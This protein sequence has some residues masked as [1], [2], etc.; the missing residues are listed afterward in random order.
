MSALHDLAAGTWALFLGTWAVRI[1]FI[2]ADC[3]PVVVKFSGGSSQYDRIVK[4]QS[5]NAVRRY[6]ED[7]QIL[8]DEAQTHARKYRA[9]LELELQEHRA[10][11]AV[12]R[13]EAVRQVERRMLRSGR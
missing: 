1:F 5:A 7:L 10:D 8:D 6:E 13:D 11:M 9:D 3:L 2:L 4:A 12:R